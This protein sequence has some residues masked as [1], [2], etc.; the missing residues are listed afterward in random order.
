MMPPSVLKAYRRSTGIPRGNARPL[1]DGRTAMGN[2]CRAYATD[3]HDGR[4]YC[5]AHAAAAREASWLAESRQ[6]APVRQEDAET[7][8]DRLRAGLVA[9]ERGFAIHGGGR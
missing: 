6:R 1:C 5:A 7:A 8:R 3:E 9:L 2:P 4:V